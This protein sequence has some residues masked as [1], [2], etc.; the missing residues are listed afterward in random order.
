MLLTELVEFSECVRVHAQ[1][2]CTVLIGLWASDCSPLTVS[3]KQIKLPFHS[4]LIIPIFLMLL[5]ALSASS[6]SALTCYII[7]LFLTEIA[8][9]L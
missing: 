7:L 5:T 9:V 6:G 4:L 3:I 2:S 8:T 1:K